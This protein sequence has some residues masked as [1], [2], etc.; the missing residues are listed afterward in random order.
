M[1]G[2]DGR[3]GKGKSGSR[4]DLRGKKAKDKKVEVG[5]G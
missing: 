1:D 4:Q 5:Q 2:G 3:G